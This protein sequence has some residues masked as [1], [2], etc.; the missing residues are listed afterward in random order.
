MRLMSMG[1]REYAKRSGTRLYA[2]LGVRDDKSSRPAGAKMDEWW[3]QWEAAGEHLEYIWV[4]WTAA[5]IQCWRVQP[6]VNGL[7]SVGL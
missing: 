2:V 5:S 6:C 4:E 1:Q 3:D 7:M